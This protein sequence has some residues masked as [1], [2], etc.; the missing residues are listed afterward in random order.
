MTR[1]VD[2]VEHVPTGGETPRN[3]AIDPSGRWLLAAN[4]NSNDIFVFLINERTG[5]LTATG[6]KVP[7]GAPVCMWL[8]CRR[9]KRRRPLLHR[10]R[11]NITLSPRVSS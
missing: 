1:R 11:G 6:Q 10:D 4:Q 3:F 8:L 2:L 9:S 5:K 7:L